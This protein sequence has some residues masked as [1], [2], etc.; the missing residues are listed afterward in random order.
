[1]EIDRNLGA[2]DADGGGRSAA[3]HSAGR[4]RKWPFPARVLVAV[5]LLP[6][7]AALILAAENDFS[8][9]GMWFDPLMIALM[10]AT[11]IVVWTTT[12]RTQ[13]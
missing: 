3:R 8:F 2:P 6:L 11:V 9:I 13:R 4:D 10:I 5:A 12:A 7:G 1:M